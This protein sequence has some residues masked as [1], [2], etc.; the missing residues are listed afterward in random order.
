MKKTNQKII[1]EYIQRLFDE[2]E[3][4]A[5]ERWDMW[6]TASTCEMDESLLAEHLEE[7][8]E[9]QKKHEEENAA[10]ER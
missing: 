3:L 4:S 9:E 2:L 6:E 7:I 10:E 1:E 8:L 5:E